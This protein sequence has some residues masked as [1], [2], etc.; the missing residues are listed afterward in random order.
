MEIEKLLNPPDVS[1][2]DKI[3]TKN[4]DDSD[5]ATV[6]D[7]QLNDEETE[8]IDQTVQP[9]NLSGPSFEDLTMELLKYTRLTKK[10]QYESRRTIQ[11][12]LFEVHADELIRSLTKR[13]EAIA[14][15]LLD[16]VLED[17]RTI[18]RSYVYPIF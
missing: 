8:D 18:N 7:E 13:S 2:S 6:D 12:G 3:K 15:K 10:I 11:L 1:N 9:Q 17:H 16:R 14:D 4:G 5:E